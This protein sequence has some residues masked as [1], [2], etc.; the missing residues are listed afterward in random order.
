MSAS[1]QQRNEGRAFYH[2]FA[3]AYDLIVE[4]PGGPEVDA[5]A[6]VFARHG[7][8]RG[9]SVVDAGCGTGA[10]ATE[11]ALRGFTVTGVDRSR[12]LVV[13]AEERARRQGAD[14]ESYCADFTLGWRPTR[15]ADGVL[16]RGVLNDLIDDDDRQRAFASFASWL[17]PDGTLLVDVRDRESSLR[18]YDG[19]RTFERRVDRDAD[20][21]TFTSTTTMEPGSDI[22]Q[23]VERWAG[24]VGDVPVDE[25]G[26]FTMRCWTWNSLEDVAHAAG[27]RNVSSLEARVVGA[28]GDRLVAVARR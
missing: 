18:R 26:T 12:D 11:L 3:W 27:F 4:R 6:A 20:T 5:V 13:Q 16:C 7:V 25:E 10:Y 21:L 17:R 14:V 23:L 2:R 15:P 24:T 19:G 9:A 28:R 22:L 1:E 8:G